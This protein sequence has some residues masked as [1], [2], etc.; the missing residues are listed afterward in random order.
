MIVHA[1][2]VIGAGAR[3]QD[4]CVVGKPL[5]AR[6][7]VER[8]RARAASARGRRSGRAPWEPGR[9]WW[10]GAASA[11]GC[12]V[13]DQAHVRERT[14]I[15]AET[16]VGRAASVENDVRV[17]ARVRMQTGAYVTAW[18][19]VEDDVFIAPGVMLTNDPTAGRR[20][21]GVELRG[22]VLRRA[23]PDRGSARCCCP[24]WRSARRPSSAPGPWSPGTSPPRDARDGS[25]RQ[26][27]AGRAGRGAP[28]RMRLR[29]RRSLAPGRG[30]L[31]LGA[32]ATATV[33]AVVVGRGRPRMAARRAPLPQETDDLLLA[34]EEAVVETA[35]VARV[36]YR[37]VS[38]R[39][40]ATFN[41]LDRVRRDVPHRPLDHLRA[42][43]A[44][45][46]SGRSAAC[47]SAAA[48]STTSCP[49]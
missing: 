16:V 30:T 2:T 15:G 47:A 18:S 3:L 43:G 19:L 14:E 17:G 25:A 45:D 27:G 37:E 9:W 7:A 44:P 1:G 21:P 26:A 35:E 10:R 24:G 49:G 34:A 20:E 28:A 12:V 8:G 48:T 32:L 46:A 22:A 4:G 29:R 42:A 5:G 33:A 31:V 13:A 6:P 40:N 36:G 39:E 23:L 41:L 11:T 38:T